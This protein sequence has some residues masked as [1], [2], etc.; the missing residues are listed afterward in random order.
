M[1][2]TTCSICSSVAFGLMFT[3][4]DCM[5]PGVIGALCQSHLHRLDFFTAAPLTVACR[6]FLPQRHLPWPAGLSY[7]NDLTVT[8]RLDHH[9]PQAA[10]EQQKSQSQS[11]RERLAQVEALCG[12]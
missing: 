3:I 8:C 5:P 2:S 4:M 9:L 12:F 1:R 10:P 6:T 11:H 7:R